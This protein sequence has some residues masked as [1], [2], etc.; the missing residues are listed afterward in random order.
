MG[1]WISRVPGVGS[2]KVGAGPS[3]RVSVS[4]I[5]AVA[6]EMRKRLRRRRMAE[7]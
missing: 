2:L 3:K 6:R 7:M 1:P 4:G 5:S